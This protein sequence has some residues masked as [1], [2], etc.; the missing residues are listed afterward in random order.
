MRS[1]NFAANYW[2]RGPGVAITATPTTKISTAQ[3]AVAGSWGGRPG[4]IKGLVQSAVS[5]AYSATTA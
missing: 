5:N 3:I 2:S 1:L 4:Q